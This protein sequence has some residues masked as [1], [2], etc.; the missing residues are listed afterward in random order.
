MLKYSVIVRTYNEER[1]IDELIHSLK[2]Q[3]VYNEAE[4]I[5]IDSESTDSTPIIL[6]KHKDIRVLKIKKTEFSYGRALNRAIS[7]S[8]GKIIACISAHCIPTDNH[9]LENLGRTFDKDDQVAFIAGRQIGIDCVRNGHPSTRFSERRIFEKMYMP[10]SIPHLK[11]PF[12]NN[13]NSAFRK[14]WWEIVPF[15]EQLPALE[16]LDFAKRIYEKGGFGAYCASCSVIHLHDENNFRVFKRFFREELALKKIKSFKKKRFTIT[17]EFIREYVSDLIHVDSLNELYSRYFITITGYRLAQYFA[18][19]LAHYGFTPHKILDLFHNQ[20]LKRITKG[21]LTT[22][23]LRSNT[24][25]HT[26]WSNRSLNFDS[27]N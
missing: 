6:K 26:I 24:E 17:L 12:L 14:E 22:N 15:C 23:E 27:T 8:H 5:V 10:Q 19:Y 3:T 13:A 18:I 11:E 7:A 25:L 20:I 1:Y 16:D 4:I 2:S 9:W 21:N